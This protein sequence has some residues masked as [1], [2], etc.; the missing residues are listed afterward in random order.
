MRRRTDGS[1]IT[2]VPTPA[3]RNGDLSGLLG[4]YIC[5]DGSVWSTNC[6]NPV[7]VTTTEGASVQARAGMVFDPTT[8]ETSTGAGRHVF[9]KN[10]QVDVVPVAPPIAKLLRDLPFPNFGNDVFNNFV[11]VSS[12]HFDSDQYDGR[13]DYSITTGTHV[14]GRY[15]I[16]DFKIYSLAAFGDIA[17]G[18]SAFGYSGR[19]VDRIRAS[20]WA[21]TTGAVPV[22]R[23]DLQENP[24]GAEGWRRRAECIAATFYH[25]GRY[26]KP[27]H[28]A[29]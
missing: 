23:E 10:D 22:H 11:F 16:A 7:L 2:T 20:L 15:T 5:A 29:P 4:V 8:G 24:A 19:S 27:A 28:Q 12:Q 17:V 21:S 1:L 18:P 3:E 26:F 13:A 6:A 25:R 9:S 14:F